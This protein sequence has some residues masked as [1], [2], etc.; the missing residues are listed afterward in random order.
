MTTEQNTPPSGETPGGVSP[1]GETPASTPGTGE[2]PGT[3][4][5]PPNAADL[6]R[7]I[8]RLSNAL[9]RA[10]A[11]AKAERETAADLKKFKE[12][13][14]TDKLSEQEKQAKQLA[15]LQRAHESALAELR[16]TR[17]LAATQLAAARL[18]FVDPDDALAFIERKR[19]ADASFDE[20]SVEDVLK[21]LLADK[22]YLAKPAQ[23]SAPEPTQ[24]QQQR[25]QP[26]SVDTRYGL[27]RPLAQQPPVTPPMNPGR[28][29]IPAPGTVPAG[30]RPSLSE[31]HELARAQGQSSGGA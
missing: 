8:E 3:T 17:L 19:R 13:I 9:K 1:Q 24:Q 4:P 27:S 12:Q 10:N 15:D 20:A 22:P 18:G 21:Q 2:T 28:S 6:Q 11:E 7:E 23:A 31:A 29:S 5:A 30:R 14:E 26:A 25:S 16:E